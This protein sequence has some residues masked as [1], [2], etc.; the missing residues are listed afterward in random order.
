[1]PHAYSVTAVAR[2]NPDR[3]RETNG[4]LVHI[5][6]GIREL[7]LTVHSTRVRRA[8]HRRP[9]RREAHGRRDLVAVPG[10]IRIRVEA[11][12]DGQYDRSAGGSALMHGTVRY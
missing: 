12:G 6:R 11:A 8:A 4:P 1:R 9:R 5:D 10:A 2:R 7:E 3:E